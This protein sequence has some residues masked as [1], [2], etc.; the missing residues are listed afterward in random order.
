MYR[1]D[2]LEGQ[3]GAYY[4]ASEQSVCPNCV[5]NPCCCEFL[6]YQSEESTEPVMENEANSDIVDELFSPERYGFTGFD[7]DGLDP[8]D[9][10]QQSAY[11]VRG[12]P[13]WIVP[14]LVKRDWNF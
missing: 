12:L 5:C 11:M 10:V 9:K 3:V 4:S 1:S 2:N 8:E 13:E 6:Y 7:W 14:Y